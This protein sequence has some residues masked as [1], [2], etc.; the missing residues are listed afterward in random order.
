MGVNKEPCMLLP[1]TTYARA[2]ENAV[3]L[4]THSMGG[5]ILKHAPAQMSGHTSQACPVQLV[6]V[7]AHLEV[8]EQPELCDSH[9]QLMIGPPRNLVGPCKPAQVRAKL[10]TS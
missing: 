8:E 7:R 1:K 2:V 6:R 5:A 3:P 4:I 9:G 10:G